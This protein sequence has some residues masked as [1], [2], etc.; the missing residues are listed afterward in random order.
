MMGKRFFLLKSFFEALETPF[1][2]YCN[3]LSLGFQNSTRIHGSFVPK[4]KDLFRPINGLY[5]KSLNSLI[6]PLEFPSEPCYAN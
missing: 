5:L 4:I 2:F 1:V 6:Q 3:R